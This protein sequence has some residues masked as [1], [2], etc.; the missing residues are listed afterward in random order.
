MPNIDL[1]K[2]R[3][4]RREAKKDGPEVTFGGKTFKL[5]VEI[6]YDL[7][8]K[9]RDASE[10]QADTV[11]LSALFG[12]KQWDAFLKLQPTLDDVSTLFESLAVEYGILAP[13]SSAS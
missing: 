12:E 3:V 9:L 13:Q 11:V 5:P 8:Q 6:P 4:A 1:D 10:D 2:A 7:V